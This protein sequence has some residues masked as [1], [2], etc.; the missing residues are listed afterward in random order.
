[1]TLAG[2]VTKSLRDPT[3]AAQRKQATWNGSPVV[4]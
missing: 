3:L 2:G 1:M 4:Y